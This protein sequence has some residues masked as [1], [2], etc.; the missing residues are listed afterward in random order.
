[1]EHLAH[2]INHAISDQPSA[3]DGNRNRLASPIRQLRN[4]DAHSPLVS[5]AR[6][7]DM[8]HGRPRRTARAKRP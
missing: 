4:R 6:A 3:I 8:S 1:M 7:L 5:V 2:T